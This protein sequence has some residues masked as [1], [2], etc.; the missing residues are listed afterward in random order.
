M[1]NYKKQIYIIGD[2]D[3]VNHRMQ[4]IGNAMKEAVERLYSWKT[5]AEQYNSL[6]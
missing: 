3:R 4:E 6:F 1:L 5:I 2:F